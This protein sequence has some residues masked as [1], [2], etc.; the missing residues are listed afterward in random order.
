MYVC[1][2]VCLF[3]EEEE[4]IGGGEPEV[5]V[6]ILQNQMDKKSGRDTI[7][8]MFMRTYTHQPTKWIY[9]I[10]LAATPHL[11][12]TSESVCGYLL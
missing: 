8:C 11:S 5:N 12:F 3:L 9:C 1:L 6:P 10:N 2:F 4:N 7:Q